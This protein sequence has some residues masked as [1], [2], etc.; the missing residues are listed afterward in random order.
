[1]NRSGQS[2]LTVRLY[3]RLA[4]E[5]R[6]SNREVRRILQA[7]GFGQIRALHPVA[8]L[9]QIIPLTA[10]LLAPLAGLP[11]AEKPEPTKPTSHATRQIEGWNVRV[12]DRLLAPPNDALGTRALRF[13]E[14][15]LSDIKAV[16]A[17][18]PLAKLQAVTIVLD[19]SHGKL[20]AMQYHPSA[21]WLKV[22]SY[23]TNLVKCVHIPEAADLPTPR[24]ITEQPWVVLHE[25]AHAYHDQ[26]LSFGDPRILQAYERFKKSGHGDA[27][28]LFNGTRVRHYGLTDHKEFFAEMTEAYFGLDDFFPFN[29]A[30]LMTAEP[31]IYELMQAIWGPVG[32]AKVKSTEK[33]ADP[34]RLTVERIFGKEEFKVPDWG[35]ARWLKDG[36]GY[37]VLEESKTLKEAKDIVR[38]EP[39]SGRRDVLVSASNLLAQGES[40]PLK[41]ED[42]A[43]SDDAAKLLIFTDTKRV[44]RKET[45]GDYWV[46]DLKRRN[47]QKLGGKAAPST[48]MFATLS[49]DGRRVAYVSRNNLYVQSLDNLRVTQLT[50]DGS[51]TIINGTS[52]WAYEEEFG[53]QNG[54]RWSPDGK[55]IAYWQF[56]TSGVREFK[57]IN[58][59][60]ALYPTITSYAY[61]KVG[62][63]NSACRVGVVRASGGKTRWFR[64]N[65]DPRNH[66]IPQMEWTKDSRHVV[67]QQ[68]NRP[69]N[70]N[71]VVRG[72]IISGDTQVLL[73][74]RDDAWVEVF[75][76]WHWI[77]NGQRFLWLSERDGWQH[78]YAVAAT[79]QKTTLLTPGMFDVIG[80]TG[81]DEQQG[82]VYFIA[83]PD[84]PT[85]RHLYRAPLDGRGAIERVSPQ[86]Q[87]GT[88]AYEM[89]KDCRWAFHTYSRFRQP[90]VIELV[91]LPEHKLVRVL[92]D[93][94]KL[95]AKLA[96]LKPCPSEFFRVGLTNGVSLDAWCLKPPDF[97]PARR[98]PLVIHVYGEPAG[99]TV[100]DGWGGEKY[101]WHCLLA[102]QG[103]VVMSIDNRGTAA[104][105]GRDW[106]KSIY[107]QVGIL[108]SADQ[109]AAARQILRERPYLDPQRIGI[110][111]W[112]GGGSMSLNAIFRYPDLYRTAMAIAFVSNQRFYD[113]IYQERYMG[114]PADNAVGFR[115]GS[116]ITFAHQLKGNLLLVYGTGDDN[117]H[118]QNCETLINELIKQNKQFSL[119]SYPNRTHAI[120][121]GDNTKRHL[122][123]TLTRYLKENLPTAR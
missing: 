32:S 115:D 45:R 111:G 101:L 28:L 11:G 62:E 97:D 68:L 120:K 22:N 108:A 119:M 87:L 2:R 123:E 113:T 59:T 38:Y 47:L 67:F 20:R 58:N 7:A 31:E 91:R 8:N 57:L 86:D 107:G 23:A 110:W 55:H 74:D 14:H 34:S 44:W 35:P 72:D 70:T 116:P 18:D 94:A 49:P 46:F 102:Q 105:R 29:R 73:T 33:P 100:V 88:H 121:E 43:W 66:Y 96:A 36:S 64:P 4:S 118:Y 1:M 79:P 24:N 21:G 69:Q 54:F 98:Y 51:D 92:A 52:D 15:K 48:L 6:W 27:A 37:T 109:A 17:A 76:Q 85:Q 13:L 114:L 112:S 12:D 82:Y 93:N 42:Y 53:L 83:S 103:Y 63:T 90:P 89:S 10:L 104:P 117:C 99:A 41:I 84:D 60:G 9:K 30:E 61:P 16:V 56:N 40:K 26:V 122:Y 95:G 78:L 75:E 5:V 19:L 3:Q 25:L 81:V 80:I 71:L 65:A 39:E 77:E 50:K 106:R